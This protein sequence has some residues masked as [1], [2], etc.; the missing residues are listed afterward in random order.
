MNLTLSHTLVYLLPFHYRVCHSVMMIGRVYKKS[1]SIIREEGKLAAQKTQ[2]LRRRYRSGKR[3]SQ[4]I[5]SMAGFFKHNN[6]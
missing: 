3:N 6:R 1:N 2:D 4:I 5:M